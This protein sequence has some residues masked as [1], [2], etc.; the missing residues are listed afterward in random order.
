MKTTSLETITDSLWFKIGKVILIFVASAWLVNE[1][2]IGKLKP[3]DTQC[4]C[5]GKDRKR[6]P[7]CPLLEPI[8]W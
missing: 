5:G 2:E 1:T 8:T 4:D 6:L 7:D 3:V